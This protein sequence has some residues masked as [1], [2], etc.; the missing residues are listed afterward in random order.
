MLDM[1]I[2]EA[3]TV[4]RVAPGS[5]LKIEIVL[6]EL[7]WAWVVRRNGEVLKADTAPT[8]CQA[9]QAAVEYINGTA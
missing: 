5:D 2:L 3:R 4:Y 6:V 9:E 7:D 1:P 8:E